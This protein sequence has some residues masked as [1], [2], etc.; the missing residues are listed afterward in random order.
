MNLKNVCCILGISK[1]EMGCEVKNLHL[2]L[3]SDL[4]SEQVLI[5]SKCQCAACA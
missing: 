3:M 2:S 4:R 1:R 5:L